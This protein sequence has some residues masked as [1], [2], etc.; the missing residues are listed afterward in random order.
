MDKKLFLPDE[1]IEELA[2]DAFGHGSFVNALYRCIKGSEHRMNIGLFGRWGVGKTSILKLLFKQISESGENMQT[3][4]FDAWKYPQG[5][6][7][8]ELVL[9]L[10]RRFGVCDQ[11]TLEKD[12][13]C[14]QEGIETAA[15]SPRQRALEVWRRF[16]Y[17][18]SLT[19]GLLIVFVLVGLLEW[20]SLVI[21]PLVIDLVIKL[22]ATS[23]ETR[24]V[25][26]L[27][28]K[29]DPSRV[30]ARFRE[31]VGRITKQSGAGKLVIAVDNLDRCSTGDAVAMLESIKALMEHER[32]LYLVA[33]NDDALTKELVSTR[34]YTYR[35]ASD[36]MRKVFQTSVVIPPLLSAD[37]ERF[38][39]SLLDRL[40]I[41]YTGQVMQVVVNAF[42]DN[43][44]KI[45]QFLNN[46]TTQYILAEEREKAG[47]LAPAEITGNDGFLAKTL[48]IRQE[49]PLFYEQLSDREDLLEEVEAHFTGV[50]PVP[51][52][53]NLTGTD[54]AD[55]FE[56]NPGLAQFLRSTRLVTVDDVS[57]F[58]RLNKEVFTSTISS[59]KELKLQVN[60]GNTEY[61][62]DAFDRLDSEDQKEV[63]VRELLSHVNREASAG[64]YDWGFNGIGILLKVYGEM[65]A[66]IMQDAARRIGNV[67]T[68]AGIREHLGKL[69]YDLVFSV[70]RDMSQT[71]KD[72]ILCLFAR[73]LMQDDIDMR[74]IDQLIDHYDIVPTAAVDN[75][76]EALIAAYDKSMEDVITAIRRIQEAPEV[77]NRL[78][79]SKLVEKVGSSVD[80]SASGEN[81]Q[82]VDLYMASRGLSSPSTRLGF[83][84]TL[85]SIISANRNN[86]Y[87]ETKAFGLG[88]LMKL[89]TDDIPDEGSNELCAALDEFTDLLA[90][91]SEKLHFIEASYRFFNV[92][93]DVQRDQYLRNRVLPLVHSGDVS[94][95]K[96]TLTLARQY[97]VKMLDYEFLLEGF[98]SKV[99]GDS[100]DPELICLMATD[101]PKEGKQKVRD[102]IIHLVTH[103]KPSHHTA[104]LEGFRQGHD[105]FTAS[106]ISEISEAC[107]NSSITAP[108]DQKR[109]YIEP[110]LELFS[111]NTVQFRRRF[112]DYT[113]SFIEDD[114]ATVSSMGIDCY[115]TIRDSVEEEKKKAIII[116][117]VRAVEQ[118]ASQDMIDKNS[119]HLLDLV[120]V[121]QG[122]L[123]RTD[124]ERLIDTLHALSSEAKPREMQLFGIKHLARI[125][126][127]YQRKVIVTGTLRGYLDNSDEE[128]REAA[129][130]ALQ[131]IAGGSPPDSSKTE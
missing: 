106:Q 22:S 72:A 48:I 44:R 52:G 11:R 96:K 100:P 12:I 17:S 118:R 90:Q 73:E 18:I 88:N 7:C 94:T 92:F 71:D 98:I 5:N 117:V 51:V 25:T 101:A 56:D 82:K 2:D 9:E 27:P 80:E 105:Q 78:L 86:T 36:F 46:L 45:K 61:I 50:G 67:L 43:P 64:H 55:V 108:P 32:C 34:N 49:F 59:A 93:S 29:L 62:E 75:L 69:E 4:L 8:Q 104:G 123:D 28:A 131:S 57:P 126:R 3:F 70:L 103:R 74:I 10:N 83:L 37:L 130:L 54:G 41:R 114:D 81:Q 76:T 31:I 23:G 16:R 111:E 127:F 38:A 1:P 39:H 107:L 128:I 110:I 19:I 125:S 79:S 13:Y 122:L 89:D 109:E 6:L 21:L 65:P 112:A 91:P 60:R 47:V 30:E 15:E 24:K 84:R 95:L 26:T 121:E 129:Q 14:I 85:L 99:Q 102:M 77:A 53:S 87:D 68:L 40:E 113:A 63:F 35:D 116:R 58:L 120:M 115:N 66:S 42:M 33:C 20:V 97:R 119:E 124:M